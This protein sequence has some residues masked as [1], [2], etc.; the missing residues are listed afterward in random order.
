MRQRH[1]LHQVFN[2]F[3]AANV[4]HHAM[5]AFAQVYGF[6]AAM[7]RFRGKNLDAWRQVTWLKCKK[8]GASQNTL[9]KYR[10]EYYCEHHLPAEAARLFR[11]SRHDR[12]K[13]TTR[14]SR[15]TA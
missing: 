4:R 2:R 13:R 6:L 1:N 10:D 14:N 12:R 9:R 15:K 3:E 11:M 5:T 8:C 7:L